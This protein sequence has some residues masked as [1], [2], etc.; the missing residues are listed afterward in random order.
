MVKNKGK[1][2]NFNKRELLSKLLLKNQTTKSIG[3]I[4][5]YSPTTISREIKRNRQKFKD[6]EITNHPCT[7]CIYQHFCK[8]KH[9][10]GQSICSQFCANCQAIKSC[11]RYVKLKCNI[12]NHWP[13]Y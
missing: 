11:N 4:I 9:V 2:F 10:C 6:S 5:G 1:Q 3:E 7:T 12:Q 8:I 13:F